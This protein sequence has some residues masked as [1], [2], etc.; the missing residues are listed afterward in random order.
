MTNL[1]HSKVNPKEKQDKEKGFVTLISVLVV[2]AVGTAVTVSLILLGLA[3]S[4]TSFAIEQS[5]QAK[6]LANACIEEALQRIRELT[7][8]TGSGN[9]SFGQG[10]CSYTVV[11]TGGSTRLVTASGS[12]GT[13]IRKTSVSVNAI[14]PLI[15]LTSWQEV[16]S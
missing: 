14:N 16:S 12:V 6:G 1:F 11:N 10:T 5:N 13:L 9:L 15:L 4:R 7:A 3:S 8:F 2:G